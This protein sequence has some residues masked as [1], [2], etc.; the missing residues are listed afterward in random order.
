MWAYLFPDSKIIVT[1]S[2]QVKITGVLA[3][4]HSRIAYFIRDLGLTNMTI[5]Y[6]SGRF[7]FPRSVDAGTQQR[8][9][10][11]LSAEIPL[12]RNC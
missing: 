11:F 10:N 6:G 7:Y 5:R 2:G 3:R 4:Y 9:R 1:R 12:V 8:L